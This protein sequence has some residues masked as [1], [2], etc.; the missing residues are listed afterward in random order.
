MEDLLKKCIQDYKYKDITLDDM[1]AK[2]VHFSNAYTVF[3]QCI[4]D[5]VSK[6][7]LDYKWNNKPLDDTI[8]EVKW[9]IN[10]SMG[11]NITPEDSSSIYRLKLLENSLK[12]LLQQGNKP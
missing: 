7:L 2:L 3:P 10:N 4:K 12:A 9:L 6:I 5:P 8:I 1:C 11:I